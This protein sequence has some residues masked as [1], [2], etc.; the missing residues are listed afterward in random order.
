MGANGANSFP[1][2]EEEGSYGSTITRA[3]RMRAVFDTCGLAGRPML[4]TEGSWGNSNVTDPETQVAWLARY[5]LLQAGLR[6]T[7]DLQMVSWFCWG[8]S[9][10]GWGNLETG[11]GLANAAAKA[12][13]IV[14]EWVVGAR[15]AAPFAGGT[16][17]TWVGTLT[18]AGGYVG[19][20]VWNT[21]GPATYTPPGPNYTRYRDLT[22]GSF[23]I[24]PGGTVPIGA[25]PVL[26]EK[27]T[28]TSSVPAA[29]AA[30]ALL[31]TPSVTR[32]AAQIQ[33]GA[34]LGGAGRVEILDAL[35]RVIRTLRVS[36]RSTAVTWDGR[37]ADG[38]L[39]AIGVYL[40]RLVC[41]GFVATGRLAVER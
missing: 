27:G 26:V 8:D 24:A 35:G 10:F 3:T 17:G 33:F 41:P 25:K 14:F 28:N 2:P 31:I 38:R 23:P 22:G 29:A 9:L 4:M 20:V 36:V 16:D 19:K 18:R 21:Q 1:M 12:Y 6:S 7:T 40:V 11:A 13:S 32:A 37:G 5:L 15:I 34:A 39:A 30:P